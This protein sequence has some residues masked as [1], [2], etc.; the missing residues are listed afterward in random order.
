MSIWTPYNLAL[1]LDTSM[2]LQMASNQFADMVEFFQ[3]AETKDKMNVLADNLRKLPKQEIFYRIKKIAA[4]N[5]L[6]KKIN[7]NKI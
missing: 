1:E 4:L 6:L 3:Q 5:L 7:L 2:H